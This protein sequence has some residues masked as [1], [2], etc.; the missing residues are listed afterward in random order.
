VSK[1]QT[2]LETN[3]SFNRGRIVYIICQTLLYA[4]YLCLVPLAVHAMVTNGLQSRPRKWLLAIITSMFALTTMYWIVSIVFTFLKIDLWNTIVTTCYGSQNAYSCIV[5]E[6][7]TNHILMTTHWLEMFYDILFVNFI[8]ADGVLVWR[9]WVLC[10]DQSRI[11]LRFPVVILGINIIIYLMNIVA[12]A[13]Q[14]LLVSKREG[15]D[16]QIFSI[17]RHIVS[18]TQPVHLTLSLLINIF[19]TSIITHKAW[20]YRK[21]MMEGGIGIRTP[22]QV[23][24]ILAILVESGMIYILIGVTSVVFI[25]VSLRLKIVEITCTSMLVGIQ[26]AG[27]YPIVVILLVEKHRSLNSTYFS[28][29]TII[30][31]RGDHTL[32]VEPIAFA[33][34]S[35]L[36][37]GGDTVSLTKPPHTTTHVTFD[38][39]LEPGDAGMDAG[40]SKISNEGHGAVLLVA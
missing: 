22:K 36:V 29:G 8:I 18:I 25:F 26:L 19:A 12:R 34:G 37:S 16:L 30:N 10:S 35:I 40:N 15:R 33:S 11:V 27:I 9:A 6:A 5:R 13:I 21:L 39:M 17:T 23:L 7:D 1:L 38:H 28:S 14:L 4:I 3:N 31:V 2:L 32:Q 24:R 20:K